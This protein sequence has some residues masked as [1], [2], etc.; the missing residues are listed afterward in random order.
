MSIDNA[1]TDAPVSQETPAE[2]RDVA[3]QE[4]E[5]DEEVEQ[6]EDAPFA[7]TVVLPHDGKKF[8]IPVC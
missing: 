1:E 8:E 5:G 4:A 6:A 7:V 2:S 3:Q